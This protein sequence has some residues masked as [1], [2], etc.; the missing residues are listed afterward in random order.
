MVETWA[1]TQTPGLGKCGSRDGGLYPM[2][3]GE[4]AGRSMEADAVPIAVE[5]ARELKRPVQ[6][7]LSQ[8]V[9]QNQ[10]RV[11]PGALARMTAL[12]GAGGLTAAWQMRVATADGL[13]SAFARLDGKD[14]PRRARSNCFGRRDAPLLDAERPD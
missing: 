4:P 2:A 13:G 1:A 6:V 8:S 14:V 3:V 11:A 12:P 7:T 5:L 10:D 9:G